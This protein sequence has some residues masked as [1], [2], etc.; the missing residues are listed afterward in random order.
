MLQNMQRPFSLRCWRSSG[1]SF[2]SLPSL[3]SAGGFLEVEA[4]GGDD[5]V[6]PEDAG[7]ELLEVEEELFLFLFRF[8]C[9][10]PEP[11]G[12]DELEVEVN[13][14]LPEPEKV[15]VFFRG[16]EFLVFRLSYDFCSS[17]SQ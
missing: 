16:F 2:P 7:D 11:E 6:D 17:R 8:P 12:D 13:E 15:E 3:S 9:L 4:D 10:L 1:V 14:A 5:G